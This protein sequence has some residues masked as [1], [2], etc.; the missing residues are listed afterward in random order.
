MRWIT[1]SL[2]VVMI[3]LRQ[4][5]FF[6]IDSENKQIIVAYEDVELRQSHCGVSALVL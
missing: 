3:N 4:M 1:I 2:L 6:C 5:D